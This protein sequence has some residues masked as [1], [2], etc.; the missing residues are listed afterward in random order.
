MLSFNWA[1]PELDLKKL[2]A[3]RSS[4]V[5]EKSRDK[6]RPSPFKII[7]FIL[8]PVLNRFLKRGSSISQ[9]LSVI[10]TMQQQIEFL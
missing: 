9:A 7:A 4:Y 10:S 5:V 6:R 1:Q 2:L 8:P 3:W